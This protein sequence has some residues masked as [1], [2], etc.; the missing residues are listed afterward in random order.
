MAEQVAGKQGPEIQLRVL[1]TDSEEARSLGIKSALGV[2]VNGQKVPIR[3]VL[4]KAA[5]EEIISSYMH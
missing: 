5:F 3:N 1:S 2:F 4:D